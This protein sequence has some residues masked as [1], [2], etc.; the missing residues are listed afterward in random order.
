V[1][2]TVVG[3]CLF[4]LV[5]LAHPTGV[6]LGVVLAALQFAVELVV[7]RNYGLALLFITPL[8][9]LISAQA[10]DVEGVVVDRVGD[11]L[12]GAVI[13]MVVLLAALVIRSRGTS[14]AP[15]SGAA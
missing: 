14:R 1:L 2:G 11:T 5:Q 13:A 7:I 4:A 10:G 8:A 12:L 3:V 6:W 9:L 15:G